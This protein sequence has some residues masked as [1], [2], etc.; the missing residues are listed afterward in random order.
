MQEVGGRD[1][2][3]RGR[4]MIKAPSCNRKTDAISSPTNKRHCRPSYANR[5]HK[6]CGAVYEYRSTRTSNSKHHRKS[7]RL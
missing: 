4:H 7:L 3:S 1:N 2:A 6:P 5:H